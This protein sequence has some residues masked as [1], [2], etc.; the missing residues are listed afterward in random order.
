MTSGYGFSGGQG[1]CHS[2]WL[3]FSDCLRDLPERVSQQDARACLLIREDYFECVAPQTEGL[4]REA[5]CL[6]A[7]KEMRYRQAVAKREAEVAKTGPVAVAATS[8]GPG[9]G[10][11]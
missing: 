3:R 4:T 5:R 2:L 9:D 11:H 7:K 1:R 8:D 10:H 6:H